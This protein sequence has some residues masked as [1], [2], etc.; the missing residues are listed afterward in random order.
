MAR[1]T[2]LAGRTSSR[3]GGGG[4]EDRFGWQDIVQGSRRRQGRPVWLAGH[5]P[6]KEAAARKIGLAGRTSS[7]EGGG[8]KEDR[9]GWQ[10]IVQGRRRR[11]GRPV[12]LAGHRPGK[13]E[14]A[15][16]TGLAGGT[17]S[18]EAGGGKEDRFGWQDIV[19]GRRRRQGRPVWLAGHRPGKQA[20]ARKTGLAGRTSSREGGG[21]KEDRFGWKDIVQGR[22]RRQGIPVWLAGHRPGK[23]EAARKT[24][25][26]GIET[27]Y[28]T[29]IA[30]R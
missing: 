21:G 14:A 5:R 7:R 12:W 28:L 19:Q 11:Q 8:G 15:R 25:L 18:R 27:A 17:S 1:K 24:G 10:D 6:G 29:T 9:F 26:A 20:A 23:E 22:R 13:E 30:R 3:E 2:G 16:K 4:K